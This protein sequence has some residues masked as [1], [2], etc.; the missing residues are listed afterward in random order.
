MLILKLFLLITLLG[1][2]LWYTPFHSNSYHLNI[3][4]LSFKTSVK[5]AYSGFNYRVDRLR[6]K[7]EK[8]DL[9]SLL[10]IRFPGVYCFQL[11]FICDAT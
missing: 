6:L 4:N 5:G 9:E 10:M 7:A 1:C 3:L 2:F 8:V 11:K